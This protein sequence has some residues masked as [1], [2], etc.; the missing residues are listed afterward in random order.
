MIWQWL[1]TQDLQ[2]DLVDWARPHG[3]DWVSLWRGC[4]RGDWLLTLCVLLRVEPYRIVDAACRCARLGTAYL[5]DGD[6]LV[7]VALTAL[8]KQVAESQSDGD[9]GGRLAALRE[10]AQGAT[11]PAVAAVFNAAVACFEALDQP[12]RAV[13][14]ALLISEAA[15][16]DAGDCAMM[17]A[18]RFTQ[19]R[20]A[21][22]V[23]DAVPLDAVLACADRRLG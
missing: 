21:E 11:D 1:Q 8:Q 19:Q 20:C 14:A 12:Q 3:D 18:L 13:A 6:E 9:M 17:S 15:I 16:L 2:Q 4:P 10:S 22:L 7:V 5:P 23:R